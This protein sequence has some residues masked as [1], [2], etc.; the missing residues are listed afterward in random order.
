MIENRNQIAYEIKR[1]RVQW[2]FYTPTSINTE[3]QRDMMLGKLMLIVTEVTECCHSTSEQN[4][5]EEMADI[6]I[7]IMDITAA[8]EIDLDGAIREIM[9]A[10]TF[11]ADLIDIVNQV[12]LAAEAVRHN[13]VAGLTKALAH[14]FW[15]LEMWAQGNFDLRAE[16]ETKMKVNWQRPIKHGKLCSL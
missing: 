5:R 13:D 16:I 12:S 1:W 15:Y 4:F 7:R 8:C 14:A 6:A 3:Q 2:G 11:N 9:D 10:V